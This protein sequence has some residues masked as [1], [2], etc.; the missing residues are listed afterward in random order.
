MTYNVATK[1]LHNYVTE[2]SGDLAAAIRSLRPGFQQQTTALAAQANI[3][4]SR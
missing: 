4:L 2:T 1:R 3:N